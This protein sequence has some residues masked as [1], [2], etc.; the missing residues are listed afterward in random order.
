[1]SQGW[2]DDPEFVEDLESC[3]LSVVLLAIAGLVLL[4]TIVV[5]KMFGVR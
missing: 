4:A 3:C 2:R 5:A 1:M